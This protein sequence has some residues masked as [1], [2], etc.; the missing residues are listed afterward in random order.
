[1]PFVVDAS[2]AIAW[3]LQEIHPTAAVALAR[4]ENDEAVV[5]TLWWFELRNGLI[6]ERRGRTP[7][8]VPHNSCKKLSISL[9]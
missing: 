7:N 4:L 6:N 8:V 9:F 3:A 1:M 5:P 2:V